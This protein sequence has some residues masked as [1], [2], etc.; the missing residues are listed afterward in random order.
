MNLIKWLKRKLGS[1]EPENHGCFDRL[2]KAEAMPMKEVIQG[3][4]KDPIENGFMVTRVTS[5][6][7]EPSKRG[8]YPV[9]IH[10][11]MDGC[12]Y[13]FYTSSTYLGKYKK[14]T[15]VY[16]RPLH[17]YEDGNIKGWMNTHKDRLKKWE[18]EQA[19]FILS[20]F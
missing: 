7:K 4:L 10:S 19:D 13:H 16:I 11:L 3:T 15:V 17:I 9:Y 14:D 12:D 1:E 18:K 6:S 20:S 8:L 5:V 2:D